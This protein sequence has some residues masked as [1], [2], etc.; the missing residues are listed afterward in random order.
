MQIHELN[1]FSGTLNDSVYLAVDN[2]AD[3]TKIPATDFADLVDNTKVNLPTDVYD[4]PTYGAAGQVLRT[5]GNGAT[6]WAT[7]GQ[8]TDAQTAQAVSDWLDEHPEATTTVEDGSIT[9]AKLQDST[10]SSAKL[11]NELMGDILAT[12]INS[13]ALSAEKILNFSDLNVSE[14]NFQ[15]C[16]YDSIRNHYVL[17]FTDDTDAKVVTISEDWETINTYD[18][19]NAYHA[20]DITYNPNQDRIYLATMT[21]NILVLNPEDMSVVNT[22]DFGEQITQIAYDGDEDVFYVGRTATNNVFYKCN[23]AMEKIKTY[24]EFTLR[25]VRELLGLDSSMTFVPQSACVV[26]GCL[27]LVAYTW[28]GSYEVNTSGYVILITPN[29]NYAISFSTAYAGEEPESLLLRGNI[30]YFM[31][32]R[33]VSETKCQV[34]VYKASFSKTLAFDKDPYFRGKAIHDIDLN[35]LIEIGNY[36]SKN[37]SATSTILNSPVASSFTLLVRIQGYENTRQILFGDS[38]TD[39]YTRVIY[40]ST[41]YIEPWYRIQMN[42]VNASW[43][44]IRLSSDTSVAFYYRKI[45][46]NQV[47]WKLDTA[48]TKHPTQTTI[49][50][51]PSGFIPNSGW[52][53]ALARWINNGTQGVNA[54]RITTN[55]EIQIIATDDYV[56]GSGIFSIN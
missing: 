4:Q 6:E 10:I 25:S 24:S 3:T 49:G 51:L 12:N 11:D 31:S 42:S 20:N 39:I 41:G 2:G 8:P 36:F 55:G 27:Y 48:E 53:F 54:L 33:R 26:D 38:V 30:G 22:I 9:N 40:P 17:A 19:L 56:H 52:H 37:T 32:W 34:V 29:E 47:E 7:V 28:S 46:V 13:I 18:V 44:T 35:E 50:I 1:T 23:T 16:T 21:N 14:V 5:K 43:Y 45:S 15:C